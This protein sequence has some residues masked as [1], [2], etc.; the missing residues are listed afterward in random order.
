MD[1]A[2]K[3]ISAVVITHNVAET[4][5]QC[6]TALK[7]VCAEVIV[8]DSY[9]DD[10]T[11][12]I[13]QELGV[14]ILSQDWLGYSG[15]KNFGN[16]RTKHDWIL[17]IDSDEILSDELIDS[18]RNVQLEKKHVYVLDRL[19]NFC[20][21]WIYHSGWYPEWKIRLFHKNHI[22]W[23]GD[24]VHESLS[25]PAD[26]KKI[27]LKGKLYH[28]SYKD[29]A[30]HIRRIKKYA[31]LSAQERFKDGKKSSFVK[32]WLSPIARFI[33]TYFIKKGFMDGKEGWLISWRSAYM[34]NLRYRILNEMWKNQIHED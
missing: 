28:Y 32:I 22:Y 4:I 24:Y 31:K 8:V 27:K 7:K 1:Q 12:E 10:G 21:K 30:D 18:L 5:G 6:L 2:I 34:V 19:T 15:T 29:T 20:G 13:C 16:A 33:R 14:T 25:I 11:V 17:S 26:F 23:K 3:P 9:S